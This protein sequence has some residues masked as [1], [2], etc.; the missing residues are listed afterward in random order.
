[1]AS[2]RGS[3]GLVVTPSDRSSFALALPHTVILYEY[4]LCKYNISLRDASMA[5]DEGGRGIDEKHCRQ[6]ALSGS[7]QERRANSLAWCL[8]SGNSMSFRL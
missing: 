2:S 4:L 1:M 7:S 3:L 8:T 6:V 5:T